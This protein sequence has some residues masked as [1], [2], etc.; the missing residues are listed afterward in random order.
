MKRTLL[1]SL[2]Y[3]VFG[4]AYATFSWVDIR[5]ESTAAEE[6]KSL[7][8][9]ADTI[10]IRDRAG[11]FINDSRNNPFDL[12]D[13]SIIQK[14]VEY[15][16][17]T[18]RYII[19]EKIGSD[20][21]R[22]PTYMTFE[23]YINWRA[24]QQQR[25]YFARMAG[26]G[27]AS[28]PLKRDPLGKVDVSRSLVD[29]LFGGSNVDIKPQGNIDVIIGVN[30]QRVANPVLLARQQNNT[31]FNFDMNINMNVS[32]QIGQKLKL[33]ANYNTQATF[34]FDNQMRLEYDSE[35][36][37][38]DEIIK[39]VEA[40]NV[41]LPLRSNL[42][43]GAQ[44]LF[45]V[46][47]ELQ[48][49]RLRLTAI[50]S[51]QRSQSQNLQVQGGAQQQFFE[52][53]ADEYDE[54][55]HFFISHFNRETFEGA[56]S[57]LP[58]VNSVFKINRID[59]YVTNERN[60][61]EGVRD[62]L[63]LSD[64]GELTRPTASNVVPGPGSMNT[65]I[66]GQYPLPA[67][68][69]NTLYREILNRPGVRTLDNA[70]NTLQSPPFN[71]VQAK[72]FE[73]V[74]ARKLMPSEYTVNWDLGYISLNTTLRPDQV[75]GVAYE[76]VYN[77]VTYQ[78]GEF[79][80]EVPSAQG[81]DLGVLF[82]RMLK[83]T[84]PRVD[85]PNW[86]LMMKN[87]YNINAYQVSQQDFRLDILYEDPGGGEKRFL[88]SSNL[89]SIPLIRV[90]NLDNL[91][92]NGDPGPDG[93]FDFVDGLTINT[94]NGRIMFPVLEPFG[95]SLTQQID[96]P[97]QRQRYDYQVL[98]DSTVTRA[99]EYPELNRFTIRGSFKSTVT[100]EINLGAFNIPQG[101]VRVTA[102]ALPLVE[103]VD[104]EIDYGLGRVRILN[105]ALL[106]PGNQVNVTFENNALFSFQQKTML[107]LR[108]EY[109]VSK[110]LQIGGTYMHLF[111][112]PFTQKVNLGD[113][114][115]NNRIVGLDLN[116]SNEVPW[117]TRMV[118]KL[119][120]YS[121]KE[122][123]RV[124]LSAE[125][126]A[127]RPGNARAINQNG[128]GAV[129]IDDF[130]GT[131]ARIDLRTP[132][133]AWVI[134]SVPQYVRRDG[135]R[136]FPESELINNRLGGVNRALLTW[137]RIDNIGRSA[138]D[139]Q[140]A[141]TRP[142]NL[143]EIFQNA[144]IQ[145]G[146][147]NIVQIFDMTYYPDERGPYNY[148]V[149][150]GSQYSAGLSPDG[151]LLEPQTRFGGIMRALTTNDFEAA[152]V[153]YVEFWMLSPFLEKPDNSPISGPGKITINLGNISEDILRDSRLF[154]ENGVPIPSQPNTRVDRTNWGIIPRVAQIVPAFD[155]DEVSRQAQ[156]VGLDG[157]DDDAEREFLADYIAQLQS[158]NADAL[159]SIIADPANDN[160]RH[161]QD[162]TFPDNTP[163]IARY[164]QW[165]NQQGNSQSPRGVGFN[166]AYT[167]IPDSED[168]NRD[169]TLNE[170]ESYYEYVIPVEPDGLGG[171]DFRNNDFITDRVETRP[172]EFWYRFKVPVA[173]FSR[174]VNGINDFRSIRFIRMYLTE[175]DQT[176]TFRFAR[177]ELVRNQWRRYLRDL[178]E[179]GIVFPGDEDDNVFFDLAAVNF[180]ENSGKL[181]FN[182]VIPPGIIREQAIGAFPDVFQN[183]QSL[184]F[185]VCNLGDGNAVGA[186]R[187][188]Q[189]DLR[190]FDNLR[191]F[192]HAEER[193]RA[194]DPIPP[195]KVSLFLRIGSDFTN[196]YYEYEIP[197]TMSDPALG[198]RDARNI[199]LA[200]NE[201]NF[202]LDLF[203]N[204]KVERNTSNIP[205]TQVYE[206]DD[207]TNP[208][209]KIKVIGNPNLGLVR[210]IM[211]GVKNI[212]NDNQSRC[213]EVW[214]NELRVTGFDQKGGVAAQVRASIELADLGNIGISGNY[215]NIGWGGIEQRLQERSREDIFD[216][217]L[218]ANLQLGKFINNGE[219]FQLPFFAQYSSITRTP[220]FD[221]YDL[222]IELRDKLNAT[223]DRF[224]RDSL[225]RQAID[226]QTIRS[227][228]FTNVRKDASGK[229]I[230]PWSLSNFSLTYAFAQIE[231][232]D[233]F[234]EFDRLT[235]NR[236]IIDY[237]YS[238]SPT[239]ITPFKKMIKKDKYL[240]FITEFN[241]NP[242]P[243]SFGVTNTFDRMY[244]QRL[245]RFSDPSQSIWVNKQFLWDRNYNLNWDFTKSLKFTFNAMAN[246]IIDE[247]PEIDSEGRF[248][249]VDRAAN[250]Q[251]I[252]DNIMDMGR[253]RNYMHNYNISYTVPLKNFPFLDFMNVRANV[254][255]TYAWNRAALGQ[256][257]IGNVIQNSQTRGVNGDFSFDRLYNKSKYLQK[258]DR[259]K[260]PVAP[261]RAAARG[262]R[263]MD[264]FGGAKGADQD[265]KDPKG[266]DKTKESG[267]S[268]IERIL[269]RPLL[270]VRKLRV[271]FSQN[272]RSVVPGFAPTPTLMGLANNWSSPGWRYIAGLTPTDA[273][274][275]RFA[276]NQWIVDT[277][278]LNQQVMR[279]LT[280]TFDARLTLEPFRD[281]KIDLDVSRSMTFNNTLFL[282]DTEPD[283]I[284]NVRRILPRDIGSFNMSFMAINTL[285]NNDIISLFKDYESN[286]TR[287]SRRVAQ[288][289]GQPD[290]TEHPLDG[291]DYADGLGRFQ[292]DVLIPAF[293]ATY[294]GT[295]VDQ[296]KLDFMK[297]LPSPNWNVSYEGLA[298][299]PAFQQLFSSVRISHSYSSNLTV[300]TFNSSAKWTEESLVVNEVTSN[301]F[302]RFEIPTIVIN[303]TMN[304]LLGID[305]KTKNDIRVRVDMRTN[306]NLAMSFIDFQLSETKTSEYIVGFGYEIKNVQIGL[307]QPRQN[308][309]DA[310]NRKP[311]T[312]TIQGQRNAASNRNAAPT[313]NLRINFD[314]SLRD[315][316]TVIH[317]LDQEQPP[318]PTRG[319]R[320][321]R[322]SPNVE[323]D[324]NR[325]LTIRLFVDYTRSVPATTI[326]FPITNVN[327]GIRVRFSLN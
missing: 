137:Y 68:D 191:M 159:Q 322:I 280:E 258:I 173:Q 217:D 279:S 158:L 38:E 74:R 237:N 168:I 309:R 51:Q 197:L 121:T 247:L 6:S 302:S 106:A 156:D 30:H 218:T 98:Y 174:A 310:R 192:V 107:G 319:L 102:G 32:G 125:V 160:F 220:Q 225:R 244:Q 16:P 165:N 17:E 69:V 97:I 175:F 195:G 124:S 52:V 67:N 151:K 25:D 15:D 297:I 128:E 306:R 21:Y 161:F 54:N 37:S 77:G 298:K 277:F 253:M 1:I 43:K 207:P 49:G 57:Q 194:N 229:K 177:F 264:Q 265:A 108:A 325:S 243:N 100:S 109:E 75:L 240:K 231:R 235:Q 7:S 119:P 268:D 245:F 189:T 116:Y 114:P 315:D 304:P 135:Q 19:R 142:V 93:V 271:N 224:I 317:L 212:G 39:K 185:N 83:S 227:Y 292:Q 278:L 155:I 209:N 59:V 316:I 136:L 34:D 288:E 58:F 262:G 3:F 88:P 118:D 80:N 23:E 272:A 5:P 61:A 56:L 307:F 144:S 76:Y 146:L 70:V 313:N 46:K 134:S 219:G 130:E 230:M 123:S 169:N 96:D 103:G 44:S 200:E 290:G 275:D 274:L 269:I 257:F 28:G 120:F 221:P 99:R 82:V 35:A 210:G 132:A 10:P 140:N 234:I 13:P 2:L 233:P 203:R 223:Q 201:L 215:S 180:D 236:G 289:L 95:S 18:N 238:R 72:D 296:M 208:D 126:A 249:P 308:T 9:E 133:N 14:D 299:L 22:Q 26:L 66:T 53:K 164:K 239:Y 267:P 211:I 270:T 24:E 143:Q 187:L 113:D 172:G 263:A 63:A 193:D 314:F 281:F 259:G 12:R 90:F 248:Q 246:A 154:F 266:K 42:I 301:Y 320:T 323:Y 216:Y 303:E 129:Y 8:L 284:Y 312:S 254:N 228:N 36:F 141:Y 167:N 81:E 184:A 153:E 41:S 295:P 105:D 89:A 110:N 261:Q 318:I 256:E 139:Q 40:G 183:E 85:I 166:T 104:Y 29:R 181:P 286:R 226:R 305:I 152:N 11:D 273:E 147:N 47:T 111:E 311:D 285:F 94:R 251:F 122:P 214:A 178:R 163:V 84:T 291:P 27:S 321:T 190:L 157:L 276:E 300:N 150:G 149:P 86:H 131:I 232:S 73:K 171:I 145:P 148:D 205:L 71:L 327:S 179:P 176:A 33:N 188:M 48:F 62:I 92:M 65:D 196:N 112:R 138:A 45:G 204:L 4:M 222:D 198:V 202:S 170:T 186:Y 31:I 182:Y 55:R 64:M 162:Q 87:I 260:T 326:S 293:L 115:I 206:K 78:V 324:V 255:S 79:D 101:S 60:Q 50:A 250:R 282:K 252:F 294:T 283:G 127:L 20:F 117:I 241:F 242:L 199:W 91:N 287:M 213:F